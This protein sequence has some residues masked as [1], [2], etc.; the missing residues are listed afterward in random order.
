MTQR[1]GLPTLS[2]ASSASSQQ[3]LH[4]SSSSTTVPVLPSPNPASSNAQESHSQEPQMSEVTLMSPNAL[5]SVQGSSV[6][7]SP[8]SLPQNHENPPIP[9]YSVVDPSLLRPGH[10]SM[11][12]ITPV[13]PSLP[14][15][16]TPTPPSDAQDSNNIDSTPDDPHLQTMDA[17]RLNFLRYNELHGHGGAPVTRAP[18]AVYLS[19]HRNGETD[20]D[21][22]SLGSRG[23]TDIESLPAYGENIPPR[24]SR[25]IEN[26]QEEPQTLAM[27][28]FKF[29]FFFPAFWVFGAL[30]LITPLRSPNPL[31]PEA[32][33]SAWPPNPELVAWVNEHLRT[34]EDKQ[35][36]LEKM[37]QVEMKWAK[38]CLLAIILLVAFCAAIG[39]MIFGVLKGTR[40][41][42]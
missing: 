21:G 22:L 29:G 16:L 6:N 23:Y 1:L 3:Q 2:R 38:R 15:Q 8:S 20:A 13:S 35:A 40:Q 41:G 4:A 18:E 26:S 34:E 7:G 37:Q 42:S 11:A 5:I 17:D 28:F 12:Q 10:L 19:R 27:L 39:L 24:Y 14:S 25:R 31:S 9:A 30:M 36:F 32:I 33:A